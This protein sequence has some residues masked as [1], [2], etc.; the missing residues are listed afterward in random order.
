MTQS[1][2]EFFGLNPIIKD[3]PE[4][5]KCLITKKI[6]KEL[7]YISHKYHGKFIRT[8]S[9][10][11][12]YF[13]LLFKNTIKIWNREE[14][15]HSF[16]EKNKAKLII[17]SNHNK[18]LLIFHEKN[19]IEK[20]VSA[21]L[22]INKIPVTFYIYKG[23]NW[24]SFN[25][26]ENRILTINYWYNKK[27]AILW[28]LMGKRISIL[29][30]NESV[31]FAKFSKDGNKVLTTSY[32]KAKLWDI[33][34]NCLVNFNHEKICLALFTKKEDKVLTLSNHTKLWNL[35]GKLLTTYKNTNAFGVIFDNSDNLL[36]LC[37]DDFAR[38][39]NPSG[40]LLTSIYQNDL[41][42]AK[43]NNQ[44]NRILTI[45]KNKYKS[46]NLWDLNGKLISKFYPNYYINS[47]KFNFKGTKILTSANNLVTL[48]DLDGKILLNLP[49]QNNVNSAKFGDKNK[50]ITITENNNLNIWNRNKL[51][52]SFPNKKKFRI[53][54]FEKNKIWAFYLSQVKLFKCFKNITLEQIL[55]IRLIALFFITKKRKINLKES[56]QE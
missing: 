48:W 44:K 24:A 16:N 26:Q 49:H 18:I 6:K 37:I 55:Y 29:Q 36:I 1:I 23:F 13:S 20:N 39:Y 15:V 10:T 14:L 42:F 53:K 2:Y 25:K 11:K 43:L 27:V 8:I 5:I 32:D 19:K 30:H 33:N 41:I 56:I 51:M 28:N 17:I 54:V 7:W 3:F 47:V 38:L 45:S 52:T 46:I 4:E 34:G 35:D 31:L 22:Y 21:K 50:I 12:T 9:P 40:K